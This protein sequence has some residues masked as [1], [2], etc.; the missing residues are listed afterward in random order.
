MRTDRRELARSAVRTGLGFAL[1]AVC[2][3]ALAQTSP[4]RLY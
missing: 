1:I 2:T 4:F 3:P